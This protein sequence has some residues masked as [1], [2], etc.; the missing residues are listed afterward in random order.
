MSK[1]SYLLGIDVGTSSSKA[2]LT[3][4][5]GRIVTSC[6]VDH[7]VSMPRAG[8][9]EHDADGVWWHDLASLCTS[10]LGLS[11]VPA[12]SI[13]AIG[14]SAISPAVVLLGDSGRPLRPGILYGIDTRASVEVAELSD[15]FSGDVEPRVDFTSQ[16][17]VPKLLWIQRNEP[18][19]W[20][21][22]DL[23]LGA[24]G[25]LVWKL[26]GSA[27]LDFYDASAYAPLFDREALRWNADYPELCPVSRLPQL[28][29]STEVVGRLTS[30]AAEL[31]GLAAGTPV[32]AGTADAAAEAT[33]C[34][35]S[36]DGDLM[37][38]YGTSSF[39]ILRSD[40]E[41]Q[42]S[43][44]RSGHYLEEGTPVVTGGMT[45]SGGFAAW[46]SALIDEGQASVD[47]QRRF[48]DLMRGAAGS[49]PG[50]RG[51]VALPYLAGE[52]SPFFDPLARGGF[53][54]LTLRHTQGDL[55]RAI[56]E[57]IGYG[58]RSIIEGLRSEGYAVGRIFAVGG[59][60]RNSLLMQLVCDIA[61]IDQIVPAPAASAAYGDALRAGVGIKLFR[62]LRA[63]A[64]TIQSAPVRVANPRHRAVYDDM[65]RIYR[66]YYSQ[67]SSIMR[68][69]SEIEN[70]ASQ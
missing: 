41:P 52:R 26:T 54:G 19:L 49:A 50:A 43:R 48:E 56:L 36:E 3:D 62:D 40:H 66:R 59:G 38:M 55:Y 46:F 63:T 17:V 64:S 14:V 2:V 6:S 16:S 37:L 20:A 51:L 24:E 5:T 68:E 27:T 9:F 10:I 42:R 60:T 33:S 45:I 11:G 58:I 39:F 47:P 18:D 1:L 57:S 53:L 67:T 35:L 8:H 7:E 29:W 22:T 4:S 25:Y 15:R 32:V 61:G 70:R 34:G 12:E 30:Q 23:V 65:Y 31:T 28:V 69:L 44:F 21:K 13:A